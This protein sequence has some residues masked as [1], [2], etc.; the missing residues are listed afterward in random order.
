MS[1]KKQS[2]RPWPK[3]AATGK[4]QAGTIPNDLHALEKILS[5]GKM[6]S[7]IKY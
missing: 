3:E 2:P 4:S 7:A 5:K 1:T 6:G